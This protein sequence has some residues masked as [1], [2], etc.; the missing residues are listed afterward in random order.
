MDG[1]L[2]SAHGA[3]VTVNED[4]S[5]R[6]VPKHNF[7]GNDT[8]VY[9]VSDIDFDYDWPGTVT[10]HV[11]SQPPPPPPPPAKPKGYW[12]VGSTGIVYS[13][14]QVARYGNAPTSSV[15][16][17][18]PTPSKRGY[19]VVNSNGAVFAFGDAKP[20]G[21]ARP[22][23]DRARASAVSPRRRPAR[24]IGSS[25]TGARSGRGVTPGP[26]ATCTR[27]R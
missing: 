2:T 9:E 22:V 19:W 24:A 3:T 26:T 15:A 6:Y 11:I 1:D 17:L 10:I 23:C 20:Y 13:F 16:H 14:G 12:M 8:F 4:G 27:S 18:E 7:K 25:R 21:S 5:F